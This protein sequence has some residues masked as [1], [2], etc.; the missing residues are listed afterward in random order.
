MPSPDTAAPP[1]GAGSALQSSLKTLG[2]TLIGVV[3][4]RL[5]L[6][7]LELEDEKHRLLGVLAWGAMAILLGGFG[8]LFFAAWITV[9]LWDTHRLLAL[10]G[11][12]ALFLGIATLACWRVRRLLSDSQQ[13]WSA[14]LAELEADRQV[15]A[16]AVGTPSSGP[17]S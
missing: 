10:G 17:V 2:A 11:F 14:S 5:S 1:P 8:L 6:L 15:L 16:A 13:A 3:H 9:M 4:T 7:A 12:S